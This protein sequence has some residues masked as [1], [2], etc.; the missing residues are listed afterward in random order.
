M[1]LQS[2]LQHTRSTQLS[3]AHWVALLHA[4]PSDRL[5]WQAPLSQKKPGRHSAPVT[6][7]EPHELPMHRLGAQLR[8][9]PAWHLAV[10]SQV[11]AARSV[12]PLQ[13][14]GAHSVPV[15]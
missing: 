11:L 6:Q 1:P 15:G 12:E 7:R 3:L 2:E 4:A 10:A 13:P 14:P 5:I 8:V 9:V